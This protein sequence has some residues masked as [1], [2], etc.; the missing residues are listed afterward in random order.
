M[1]KPFLVTIRETFEKTMIVYAADEA[2]AYTKQEHLLYSMNLE[3][4]VP[5]SR[6]VVGIVE[7]EEKQIA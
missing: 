5:G 2:E 1:N 4:Y 7:K 3:D 6:K